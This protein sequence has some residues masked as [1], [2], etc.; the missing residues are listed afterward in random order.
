MATRK[1]HLS[2]TNDEIIEFFKSL[3]L[4]TEE[5]RDVVLRHISY[6]PDQPR[7]SEVPPLTISDRTTP[8]RNH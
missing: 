7:T 1:S 6:S 5:E 2:L 3:G 8:L 4:G